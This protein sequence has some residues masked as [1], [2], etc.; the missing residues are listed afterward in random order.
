MERMK[1]QQPGQQHS[2]TGASGQ[3]VKVFMPQQYNNP[4][5]LYSAP[6]VVE[7]FAAQAEGLMDEIE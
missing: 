1:A 3:R 6:N 5:S 2:P 4:M 7:T